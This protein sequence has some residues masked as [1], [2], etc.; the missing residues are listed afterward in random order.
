[1]SS[2]LPKASHAN[3]CW[4]SKKEPRFPDSETRV[5]STGHQEAA[6]GSTSRGR[7]DEGEE[8]RM[9]AHTWRHGQISHQ[10]K[11]TGK[12]KKNQ[13][14]ATLHKSRED[15]PL[16]QMLQRCHAEQAGSSLEIR[17]KLVAF[18]TR[19]V[20]QQTLK[21]DHGELCYNGNRLRGTLKAAMRGFFSRDSTAGNSR[22]HIG[23]LNKHTSHPNFS[24]YRGDG[25]IKDFKAKGDNRYLS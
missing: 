16:R 1:M 4:Q 17:I 7:G 8:A 20:G 23:I 14:A 19:L 24:A 12:W 18:E 15:N 6:V 21:S 9:V 5:L 2:S 11:K 3:S 25:E 13:G 10:S 22:I